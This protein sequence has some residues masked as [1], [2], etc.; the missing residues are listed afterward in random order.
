M[1]LLTFL[2]LPLLMLQEVEPKPRLGAGGELW[3]SLVILEW[4]RGGECEERFVSGLLM[5]GGNTR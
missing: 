5:S 1:L 3:L 4:C 2:H